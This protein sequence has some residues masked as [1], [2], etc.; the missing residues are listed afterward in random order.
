MEEDRL[1]AGISERKKREKKS[2]QKWVSEKENRWDN[3]K[4]ERQKCLESSKVEITVCKL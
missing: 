4:S 2:F 1:V 3:W